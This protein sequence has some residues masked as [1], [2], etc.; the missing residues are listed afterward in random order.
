MSLGLI[1]E[2]IINSQKEYNKPDEDI[3]F[4]DEEFDS[5]LNYYENST[6]EKLNLI[7]LN[8]CD[9][10]VDLPFPMAS[11][12]KSKPTIVDNTLHI[13]KFIF[14]Y[15]YEMLI[16]DKIDGLAILL[17]YNR[18]IL[19]IYGNGN[20]KNQGQDLTYLSDYISFPI[21]N[22]DIAVRG[23]LVINKS[24]FLFLQETLSNDKIKMKKA[25]NLL[26][27]CFKRKDNV[28]EI[29]S[30]STFYAFEILNELLT[31]EEHIF[32]L[33]NYNFSTVF[34]QKITDIT[35][36]N[37][38]QLL[39]ERK[40][41]A[42]YDIDGLILIPNIPI[43]YPDDNKNPKNKIAF[44]VNKVGITKIK[45]IEWCLT[46]R[47][48][49]INPVIHIE[50]IELLGSDV[51][52]VTGNNAKYI[53]D[54]Q[55]GI[56]AIVEICLSGEIIPKIEKVIIPST[57]YPSVPFLYHWNSTNVEIIIND[58]NHP[59]IK[60]QEIHS[61]LN[62]LNIKSC[63]IKTIEK[64]YNNTNI[65]DIDGFLRM[66]S[67]QIS[68]IDGLGIKSSSNICEEISKGIKNFTYSKLMAASGIFGEGLSEER[69]ELF[70]DFYPNWMYIDI[71]EEQI[72]NINGFGPILSKKI[73]VNLLKFKEWL[74]EHPEFISLSR[75]NENVERD[76]VN[77]IIVFSGFRDDEFKYKLESR[78]AKV[79]SSF[80]NDTTIL[81]VKDITENSSK[82][83]KAKNLG[84]KIIGK[85]N[86]K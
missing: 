2:I 16:E 24:N 84:V 59:Q 32:K 79:K 49:V 72:K 45:D 26:S 53:I 6:D 40:K 19:K 35:Y 80:V 11:I 85:G 43:A 34:Y 56:D 47:Y 50:P 46:S 1:K 67:N 60:I 65:R 39:E 68:M 13:N 57:N 71:D 15:P 64:I 77:E 36:D 69:F 61:F 81:I 76:L 52:K 20:D 37:M 41:D 10:M 75:N 8:Q 48:G 14:E 66:K 3:K 7:E 27:G 4:S 70:I 18:G 23:E 30:Q 21:I 33:K 22:E 54:N 63:G 5:L 73:A 31:P 17:V 58:L 62:H 44:K 9:R 86:F 51:S 28:S 29:F 55:L 78:G 74:F 82:I 83:I 12:T 42:L 25:R 38:K